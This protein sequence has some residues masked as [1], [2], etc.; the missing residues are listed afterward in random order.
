MNL[1]LE[2]LCTFCAL[3]AVCVAGQDFYYDERGKTYVIDPYGNRR[4]SGSET[5]YT[6]PPRPD[7]PKEEILNFAINLFR[8]VEN[9]GAREN[10]VVAPLSPQILLSFLANE[11]SGDTKKQIVDA[12]EYNNSKELEKLLNKMQGDGTKRELKIGNAFFVNSKLQNSLK[13]SFD[14]VINKKPR[15]KRPIDGFAVDFN[16]IRGTK[17]TYNEWVNNQTHGALKDVQ[18]DFDQNTELLLASTVYFRGQWLFTFNS[19]QTSDFNLSPNETV[20]VDTMRIRK[21]FHS[22]TFDNIKAR[23]AA[24]PYN[25]TESMIVVM[26]KDGE[27]LD[28]VI[29]KMTGYDIKDIVDVVIG[30]PTLNFVNI[31]LP[32][33][34]LKTTVQLTEPLKKM[35]INDLFTQKSTLKVYDNGPTM[36]I[37]SALQQSFLEVDENGSVGA[38]TTTFSA[39][40]LTVQPETKHTDFIVNQ[41]FAVFIVDRRYAVPYFMAKIYDPRK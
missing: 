5:R 41:P 17:K 23:W 28:N 33:F 39:I 31:T 12:T 8:N 19:T 15:N 37:G 22:G 34:K 21:K 40:A 9:Q 25:S 14:V 20:Q 13:N 24:I 16:D 26:P 32:K 3:M 35:G 30:Y 2:L 11:C 38:S 27:T 4:Y 18:S 7:R 1:V 10:Y 6:P 36:K 29:E